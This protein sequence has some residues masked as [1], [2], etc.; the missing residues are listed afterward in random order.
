MTG[1]GQ[2]QKQTGL[3]WLGRFMEAQAHVQSET[4]WATFTLGMLGAIAQTS[5]D[6]APEL[7]ARMRTDA[8]DLRDRVMELRAVTLDILANVERQVTSRN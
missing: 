8:D 5:P 6:K 7:I 3:E 1:N 2:P 4:M